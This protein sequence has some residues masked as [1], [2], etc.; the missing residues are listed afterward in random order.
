M[1]ARLTSILDTPQMTDQDALD[2]LEREAGRAQRAA[3][4]LDEV[5]VHV[6]FHTTRDV[7]LATLLA[8]LCARR[9]TTS[10]FGF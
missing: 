4:Q 8:T 10:S 7:S 6:V 9:A 3:K 1:F 2:T 5:C